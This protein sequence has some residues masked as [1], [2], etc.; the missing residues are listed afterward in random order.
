MKPPC[1]TSI[2][3][4]IGGIIA[5]YVISTL[6]MLLSLNLSD[7]VNVIQIIG[8]SLAECAIVYAIYV[9]KNWVRLFF[10]ATIAFWTVSLVV[11][12][13][14]GY[15]YHGFRLLVLTLNFTFSAVAVMFL[16]YPE[17]NDWFRKPRAP[18]A[19]ES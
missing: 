17:S 19:I 4:A 7:W 16:F 10:V 11:F 6:D 18:T 8:I 2:K 3:V 13:F 14:E 12:H 1:P 5:S 9:R 15:S